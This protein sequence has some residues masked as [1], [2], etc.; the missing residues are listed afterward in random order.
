MCIDAHMCTISKV[1]GIN[2]K[3]EICLPNKKHM[4][5]HR[6]ERTDMAAKYKIYVTVT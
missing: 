2:E 1:I 3:K 4:N 5:G 6:C